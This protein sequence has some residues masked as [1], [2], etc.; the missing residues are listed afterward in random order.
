M[1][2]K[3]G[4]KEVETFT[5]KDDTEPK[6]VI[7][8]RPMN[9]GQYLNFISYSNDIRKQLNKRHEFDPDNAEVI[10]KQLIKDGED[11]IRSFKAAIGDLSV[12]DIDFTIKL[13]K[14]LY[15]NI[16]Q[17]IEHEEESYEGKDA[18]KVIEQIHD[19]DQRKELDDWLNTLITI[20]KED[21]KNSDEQSDSTT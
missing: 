9:S 3:S 10:F 21:V 17:K 14:F 4:L 8:A 19:K 16:V 12:L 1:A 13:N 5:W 15:E 7:T 18:V 2:I 6:T 20:N 11:P